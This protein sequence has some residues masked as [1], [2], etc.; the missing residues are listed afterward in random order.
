MLSRTDAFQRSIFLRGTPWN[1]MK[2]AHYQA[3]HV[4]KNNGIY[5]SN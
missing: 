3:F 4:F 1:T 5:I 2:H